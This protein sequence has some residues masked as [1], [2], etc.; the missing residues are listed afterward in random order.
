MVKDVPIKIY[1][2]LF[3]KEETVYI[4]VFDYEE[5]HLENFNGCE[6]SYHTCPE[7]KS[8]KVKALELY[9]SN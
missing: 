7:C 4:N 8:C 3:L 9:Q 2:P 5:I 1:C 6:S